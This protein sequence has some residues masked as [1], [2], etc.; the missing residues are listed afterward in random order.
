V[1]W[2]SSQGFPVVARSDHITVYDVRA[3]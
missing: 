1:S 3:G 2:W